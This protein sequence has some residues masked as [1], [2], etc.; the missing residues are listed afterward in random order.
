MTQ[1]ER[2]QGLALVALTT[3]MWGILA[4]GLKVATERI[5]VITI[6]WFRFA[7]A[8]VMLF[9]WLAV[10]RPQDLRVLA[11]PP[12]LGIVAAICLGTNYIAYLM[13]LELTQPSNAQ[14]IIQLAP[15]FLALLGML[16][17]GE[18][19]SRKQLGFSLVAALGFALFYQDQLGILIGDSGDFTRGNLWIVL[20]AVMWALYAA[21]TKQETARGVP[22]QGLNLVLYALPALVLAPF[23]DLAALAELSSGDWLLMVYLGANTVIAYGAL[24]EGMKRLPAHESGLVISTTPLITMSVMAVL[25]ALEVEWIAHDRVSL[26]GWV[27]ALFVVGG[28][29]LVLRARD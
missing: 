2:R 3:C 22:P 21:L 29:A 28:V 26:L 8:F 6:V 12:K 23:A 27:G 7:F 13:G 4:I 10:R 9:A 15:L 5:D 18:R 14:V 20:A 16:M 17:F 24:A 19:L 1:K 11:R 25:G